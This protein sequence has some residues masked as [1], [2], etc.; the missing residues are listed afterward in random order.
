MTISSANPSGDIPGLS[1]SVTVPSLTTAVVISPDGGVQ[2]S[3]PGTAAIILDIMLFIDG[4]TTPN[5]IVQRR[6]EAVNYMLLG[7]LT[8]WSFTVSLT[9]FTPGNHDFRVAAKYYFA[10]SGTT[11]AIVAGSSVS[12]LRGS[13]TGV[14]INP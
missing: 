9:G 7:G 1:L 6:L 11:S 14:I 8:T 3:A 10:N 4:Q 2:V 13:L 12:A 5:Q